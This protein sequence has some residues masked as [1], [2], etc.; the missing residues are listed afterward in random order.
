MRDPSDDVSLRYPLG[1]VMGIPVAG[2]SIE[3]AVRTVERWVDTGHR[4]SAAGVNANVVNLAAR[5]PDFAD[6]LRANSLNYADGQSVVW[7][8]R[9]LGLGVPQRVATTDLVHPLARMC[10]RRGFGLYLLGSE[11]DVVERAGERLVLQN[12]GLRVHSHH[13]Y[14]TNDDDPDIV[15]AVN[16]SGARVLLVGMGDPKQQQWVQAHIASLS[17]NAVLT[18]GGLFDWV[19]GVNRR[20]PGW[21]VSSGLEWLWRVMIEPRRLLLRYALGNPEFLLRLALALAKRAGRQRRTSRRSTTRG[22]TH[23]PLQGM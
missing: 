9:L 19:S 13:G 5:D 18:C 16:D 12:P 1:V 6:L 8:S 2:C 14:L 4:C 11:Q 10:A 17:V 23:G 15:K 3:Q 20:P 22:Q 21:M 7:A